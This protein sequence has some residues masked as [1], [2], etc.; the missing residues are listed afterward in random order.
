MPMRPPKPCPAP[1]CNQLVASG[2]CLEHAR[3]KR[4]AFKALDENRRF[5]S[6][7]RWQKLRNWFLRRNPI[8]ASC[9]RIAKVVD[10]RLAIKDGGESTAESNL[11][12]LCND[13]HQRKRG[14]ES[15]HL[16]GG[17]SQSLLPRAPDRPPSH[18]GSAAKSE[19]IFGDD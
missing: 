3:R 7:A 16:R 6:S 15:H 9:G 13:C 14:Q 17:E 11:Q 12:A 4:A 2:H 18:I 19:K 1:G 10:H 5:Y 8:C